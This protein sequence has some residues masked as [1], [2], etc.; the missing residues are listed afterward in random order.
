MIPID[1]IQSTAETLMGKA[2][3]E[4]PEDY[5]TGLKATAEAEDGDLSSFGHP[6]QPWGPLD[7]MASKGVRSSH[8]ISMILSISV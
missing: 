6:S 5:L 8:A 2:A 3:I 1:L 7:E 4:I